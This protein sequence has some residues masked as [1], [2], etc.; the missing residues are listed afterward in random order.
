MWLRKEHCSFN[1]IKGQCP[2]CKGAGETAIQMHFMQDIF[3]ECMKCNGKR[4][5][6]EV[7]T[8]QYKGYSIADLL[9]LEIGEID[10]GKLLAV[11]DELTVKGA[12]VIV[13]EHNPLLIRQADYLIEMGPVGGRSRLLCVEARLEKV[14]HAHSCDGE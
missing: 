11:I 10:V 5:L 13:I 2:E 1:S 3:V 6:E 9:A 7:L 8:V 14:N 12:T 4:Y